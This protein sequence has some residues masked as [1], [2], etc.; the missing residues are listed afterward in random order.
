MGAELGV[1]ITTDVIY[2]GLYAYKDLWLT[3][4]LY[5]GFIALCGYGLRQW[6]AAQKQDA[7]LGATA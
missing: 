5:L 4:A 3:A 1:W 2:V 7:L 6:R